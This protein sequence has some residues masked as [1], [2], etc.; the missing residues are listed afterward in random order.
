[1]DV[2]GEFDSVKPLK[3]LQSLSYI[4][5]LGWCGYIVILTGE[6]RQLVVILIQQNHATICFK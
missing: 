2:F 4:F 3:Y 6:L 1:M 5:T